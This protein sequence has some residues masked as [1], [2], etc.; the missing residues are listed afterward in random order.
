L[1]LEVDFPPRKLFPNK[2]AHW[3]TKHKVAKKYRNDCFVLTKDAIR[4]GWIA[5]P[6]SEKIGLHLIFTPPHQRSVIPDDDNI[7]SAFKSGRDGI[8]EALG[9][10][11]RRFVT[12]KTV[13]S[14]DPACKFG[15]V[16]VELTAV[17]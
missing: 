3:G 6:D 8:A 5:L 16:R 17:R 12:T 11:D 7:E 15:K 14:R 9:V 4:R 1:P 13:L 2:K 10:N